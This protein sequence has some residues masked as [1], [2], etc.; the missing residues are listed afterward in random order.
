MTEVSEVSEG[1][2]VT[3]VFQSGLV[4]QISFCTKG[5][6]MI[7]K[8][9]FLYGI[10]LFRREKHYKCMHIR[11]Y[12]KLIVWQEAHALC[13]WIY[14]LT[15][16]FPKDERFRLVTQMCKSSYSVPTNIA[17]GS[18]KKS[19]KEREHFY[20]IASCSLEELHYQSRLVRDLG[21]IN[22]EEFRQA[23]DHIQRVS[24]LLM[25]LRKSLF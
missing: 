12:E 9:D 15:P 20:E 24:Y 18:G 21:Y 13:L 3:E 6:L 14:K 19:I 2:D 22:D 11:P 4:H 23:D 16:K 7:E 8:S 10:S 17:E 5:N 1:T 25:R